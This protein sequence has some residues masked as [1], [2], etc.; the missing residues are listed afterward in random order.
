M[1]YKISKSVQAGTAKLPEGEGITAGY[2]TAN[3]LETLAPVLGF[4]ASTVRQC[5]EEVRYFRSSIEIYDQYS[6]GT[7]K[8][9]TGDENG[10][11]CI[12]F[13]IT[14]SLFLV[15]DIRDSDGSTRQHTACL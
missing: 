1:F 5:R 13:Y 14:A 11:D 7:I 2:I 3:E 9:T 15:V 8:R 6:F 10:E 4:S 12:A